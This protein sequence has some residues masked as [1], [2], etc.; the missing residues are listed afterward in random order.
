[1]R[2]EDPDVSLAIVAALLLAMLLLAAH[3][4]RPVTHTL[5]FTTD[6]TDVARVGVLVDGAP[7]TSGVPV[8]A[9]GAWALAAHTFFGRETRVVTFDAAGQV[10]PASNARVYGGCLWDR[11]DSGRVGGPDFGIYLDEIAADTASPAEL[12]SFTA[13]FG[14]VCP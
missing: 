13:A 5:R 9:N 1:M 3:E 14:M 8:F 7:L 6:S 10:S 4:A 11:D 2:R 12:E